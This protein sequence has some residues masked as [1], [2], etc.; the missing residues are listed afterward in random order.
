MTAVRLEIRAEQGIGSGRTPSKPIA[1]NAQSA[2]APCRSFRTE[3]TTAPT[4]VEIGIEVVA[5]ILP[6]RTAVEL[7]A[8]AVSLAGRRTGAAPFYAASVGGTNLAH[9]PAALAVGTDIRA[10]RHRAPC[11]GCAELRATGHE[12]LWGRDRTLAAAVPTGRAPAAVGGSLVDA[13]VAV[14]VRSVAALGGGGRNLVVYV[15]AVVPATGTRR[16]SV[17]VSVEDVVYADATRQVTALAHGALVGVHAV[18]VAHA[19]PASDTPTSNITGLSAHALRRVH[20]MLAALGCRVAAIYR[21][22]QTII[23][24]R[25]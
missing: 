21:T 12:P 22:G 8:H 2:L 11:A 10:D 4:V 23:T 1:A 15:V 6:A 13:A 9:P 19:H 18:A 14:V 5:T 16:L 7:A 20:A 17:T 24:L 3:T 25:A